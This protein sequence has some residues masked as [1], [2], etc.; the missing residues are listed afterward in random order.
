MP[1]VDGS[2]H[3]AHQLKSMATQRPITFA[4]DVPSDAITLRNESNDRRG[5]TIVFIAAP[6][7]GCLLRFPLAQI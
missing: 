4:G 7:D 2:N 3:K 1:L 6:S 5:V